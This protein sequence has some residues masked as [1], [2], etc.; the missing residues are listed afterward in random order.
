MS[1]LLFNLEKPEYEYYSQEMI[2]AFFPG[3]KTILAGD[4]DMK[5]SQKTISNQIELKLEY[6][7]GTF[8]EKKVPVENP[9]D[10]GDKGI[11][12]GILYDFLSDHCQ[13]ELMWGN[14]TGIKP[15][16]IVQKLFKQGFNEKEIIDR[17]LTYYRTSRDRSDLLI[18]LAKKQDPFISGGQ[19]N[20]RI[21]LY[22]GIPLCPSKCSYCSFISTLVNKDKSNLNDY[23]EHLLIEIQKIAALVAKKPVIIDTIYIGGGTP[24]VLSEVQ[25]SE[26]LSLLAKEFDLSH[27]REYTLEAGR[28]DTLT[29]N[30]LIIAKKHGVDRI[31]LNPQSMNKDTLKAVSRPYQVG[32]FEKWLAI[33]KN[34]A[35]KTL[36]MDLIIGLANEAPEDFIKSLNQLLSFQPENI[37]LHN[38]SIKKGSAIKDDFGIKVK[39]GYGESFYQFV[40]EKMISFGYDPYY[41]YRLKYTYGNSEN[42]GYSKPGHEG[43][44]NIMMMSET[45]TILGIGAGT[46]GNLYFSEKDLV[47]KT[48]TVKDVKT[49]N[50]RFDEIL[51]K[52]LD[53]L[54][55]FL[56]EWPLVDK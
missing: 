10:L 15:V 38:L 9:I 1:L 16:K 46:T 24:T 6:S 21:G 48:Y 35:F 7:N 34:L 55:I 54:D 52:K 28:P 27:L 33:I 45:Q 37:T 56:N 22:L 36:N 3:V 12:K 20:N 41:L 8:F 40:K 32:E 11:Y 30:K 51:S 25:L 50:E 39:E 49:Y 14:L 17:F 47:K 23:F 26:L 31:C 18:D 4:W 2:Q 5:L 19:K 13:K 53:T 42:I 44:Y 29:E 43:V